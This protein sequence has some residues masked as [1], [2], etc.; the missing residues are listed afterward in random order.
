LPPQSLDADLEKKALA[1]AVGTAHRRWFKL[2]LGLTNYG[3]YKATAER[4]L[5][6]YSNRAGDNL[7]DV[8]MARLVLESY[9]FIRQGVL[10]K[11][12]DH[13]LTSTVG[14]Q[15]FLASRG[16][17]ASFAPLGYYPGIGENRG[18]ERDIDVLFL[19]KLT[20]RR[21]R[22]LELIVPALE[23]T[24]ARVVVI[25]EGLSGE[26]RIALLNR[27]KMVL[28]LHKYPWDTPWMRWTL[29]AANGAL[30][31]SEPLS[32]PEPF[33]PDVHYVEAPFKELPDTITCLRGDPDR[34]ARLAK[35]C[36]GF[37]KERL[38]LRESVGTLL[39]TSLPLH[40]A[41]EVDMASRHLAEGI[42]LG[43]TGA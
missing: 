7:V 1:R 36:G 27:V 20:D 4:G 28:H 29:A 25:G 13:V 9:A 5:G 41:S 22:R 33:L 8:R 17:A 15:R 23:R 43:G 16:I 24:G 10:E 35:A 11:W 3:V 32:D 37:V 2:T 31:V 38:T 21:N 12:V 19:G 6:N 26:A 40:H 14:K 30:M 42:N 18:L 39:S 34:L